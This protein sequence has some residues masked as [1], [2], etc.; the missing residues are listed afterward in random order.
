MSLKSQP[1]AFAASRTEAIVMCSV[2]RGAAR[3][4]RSDHRQPVRQCSSGSVLTERREPPLR[5]RQPGLVQECAERPHVFQAGLRF[6][7][8]S[9][10]CQTELSHSPLH[11]EVRSDC[12][13]FRSRN[14][15]ITCA[16]RVR[17][18]TDARRL[19]SLA[20][21]L[22]EGVFRR[23]SM[24]ADPQPPVRR[25]LVWGGAREA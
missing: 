22:L 21:R 7:Y 4:D 24:C 11:D 12:V 23:G 18:L 13:L 5:V 17:G 9:L 19:T 25:G 15:H 2:R 14:G 8:S 1:R 20:A 3:G 6:A 16:D 10:A